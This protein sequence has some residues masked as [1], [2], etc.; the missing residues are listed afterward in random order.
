MIIKKDG[1]REVFNTEKVR[2]GIQL[3]CQKRE[4]SMDIIEEFIDEL[5]RDLREIVAG[6]HLLPRRAGD[7]QRT[8]VGGVAVAA[9]RAGHAVAPVGGAVE[10]E[11]DKGIGISLDGL[12]AGELQGGDGLFRRAPDSAGRDPVPQRRGRNTRD[13]RQHQQ[14]YDQLDQC[15]PRLFPRHVPHL[16]NPVL[17][18]PVA[19]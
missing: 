11:T 12:G 7:G 3:A 18:H 2:S 13:D 8:A 5:E 9:R 19:C 10:P 6:D 15:K 14:G 4:I 17:R 16:V 1:R